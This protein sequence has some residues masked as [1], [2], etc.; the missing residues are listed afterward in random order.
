MNDGVIVLPRW[1]AKWNAYL[2]AN[3]DMLGSRHA[4]AASRLAAVL[5]AGEQ[6]AISIFSAEVKRRSEAAQTAGLA[7]L[8]AIERDEFVHEHC[9]R[10]LCRYLPQVDDTHAIR[11]RAQRFF[12]GLG[13]TADM[14]RHF[15]QIS[16]LDSAVCRIMWHLEQSEL[17]AASPLA[18]LST[19][20]KHD[21]ARHVCVSRR[22]ARAL[23]LGARDRGAVG[24]QVRADL[25]SMLAPVGASFEDIGVDADR[26]F[27]DIGGGSPA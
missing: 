5:L 12:A 25:V 6:S 10:N 20:I 14:G 17:P 9:L 8:R 27:D 11:R 16:H 24:E 3:G 2:A 26:L 18:L 19:R 7:Q 21:E 15:G 4:E 13:R 23:G 1:Y 22:H